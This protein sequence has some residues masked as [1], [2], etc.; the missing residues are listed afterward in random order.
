MVYQSNFRPLA[1]WRDNSASSSSSS[2]AGGIAWLFRHFSRIGG[3]SVGPPDV[4]RLGAAAS[5]APLFFI[6]NGVVVVCKKGWIKNDR[7]KLISSWSYLYYFTETF[8]ISYLSNYLSI[9]LNSNPNR[10]RN[11]LIGY[12]FDMII[13]GVCMFYVYV[14]VFV[15]KSWYWMLEVIEFAC[16]PLWVY[17]IVFM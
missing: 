14:Y 16:S 7:R 12:T 17:I 11:Q 5:S 2:E 15:L 4:R 13:Q 1:N 6:R 3:S 9:I 8:C 10:K